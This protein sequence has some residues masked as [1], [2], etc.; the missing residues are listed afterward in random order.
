MRFIATGHSLFG[1]PN[2]LL[3]G[4]GR[5]R[6]V[7]LLNR[8]LSAAPSCDRQPRARGLPLRCTHPHGRNGGVRSL[9]RSVGLRRRAAAGYASKA[10][11][12][13]VTP[14]AGIAAVVLGGVDPR[15][16][17]QLPGTVV[18]VILI[19]CCSRSFGDAEEEFGR[20]HLRLVIVAMLLIYGRGKRYSE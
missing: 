18:G 2:A 16:P 13:W 6:G 7:F 3:V 8:R 15:R 17:R 19:T 14:S 20:R 12:R 10:A 1:I 11:Q 5:R 9:R 4:S